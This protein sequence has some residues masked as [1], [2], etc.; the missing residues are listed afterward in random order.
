[1]EK[2]IMKKYHLGFKP[3]E[4]DSSKDDGVILKAQMKIAF[5][6]M[7]ESFTKKQDDEIL[8]FLY[9]KYKDTDVSDAYVLS[10]KD[11]KAFLI[12]ML[13]KWKMGR[14][15]G[16]SIKSYAIDEAI[17]P[18]ADSGEDVKEAIKR[19]RQETCP[20]TYMPDFDKEKCLQ[21]IEKSL[22]YKSLAERCWEIVKAK[23]V[24]I[25]YLE[26]SQD[27]EQYNEFA[28]QT[29]GYASQLTKAEFETL[30]EGLK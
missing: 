17:L 26:D 29:N 16:S 30:K 27:V 19:L 4:I 21:V 23:R 2:D 20:A 7:N 8:K 15:K 13:P 12:E 14:L 6:T 9:G 5:E 24:S 1:M 25:V 22:Q 11:F 3:Q 18:S 28:F 10:E